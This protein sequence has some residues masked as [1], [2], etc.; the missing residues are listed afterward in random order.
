MRYA[1]FWVRALASLLDSFVTLLV[2]VPVIVLA[3]MGWAIA[4]NDAAATGIA[5][6]VN[7]VAGWLYFALFESGRWQATP[8]KRMLGIRVTDLAGR[9]ISFGRASGRY[10]GKILSILTFYIGFIMAGLTEKK[11]GLHDKLADTLVLY[12]DANPELPDAGL[13]QAFS[14]GVAQTIYLPQSNINR[15]VMSGFDADGHVVRLSFS[16]DTPKMGQEGLIIGRD[17]KACELHMNDPS[18]SR[19]HARLFNENGTVW[20]EDLASANGTLVNGR[21]VNPGV[22]IELPRQGAVTFGAVE[23]SIAKY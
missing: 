2:V 1:G 10:F 3:T 15:W 8:G 18:V 6:I 12:G 9:P 17:A 23:L 19:R 22:A 11:Q 4:Y 7:A 14:D 5:F 21:S 16:Q 13:K 20:L